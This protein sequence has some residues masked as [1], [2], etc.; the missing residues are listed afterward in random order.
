M[1]SSRP[2][3]I[4]NSARGATGRSSP[5]PPGTGAIV[6]PDPGITGRHSGWKLKASLPAAA[7]A[8]GKVR[9]PPI[10]AKDWVFVRPSIIRQHQIATRS[11]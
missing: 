10:F 2:S 6:E 3:R 1:S 11:R 8:Q 7:E 5:P 9:P 4:E